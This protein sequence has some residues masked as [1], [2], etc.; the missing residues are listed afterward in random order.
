M[1]IYKFICDKMIDDSFGRICHKLL[2]SELL[3]LELVCKEFMN[4]I[5]KIRLHTKSFKITMNNKN[6][7]ETHQFSNVF[8]HIKDDITLLLPYVKHCRKLNL[9]YT[10]IDD[11]EHL[12]G[13]YREIILPYPIAD[14]IIDHISYGTLK[15]I[16]LVNTSVK[17][18]C[19]NIP[20]IVY[21][22]KFNDNFNIYNYINLGMS[23]RKIFN[24]LLYY[25][26]YELIE[27]ILS[28]NPICDDLI[29]ECNEKY[30]K[31][32]TMRFYMIVSR[33]Q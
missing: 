11:I 19:Q 15:N 3:L 30:S 21:D 7:L 9:A 4:F 12:T 23:P 16:S 2:L 33:I 29:F 28:F 24:L 26:I 20:I 17:Y 13:N 32:Q 5:R 10:N 27:P 14:I 25:K 22:Y 18:R 6:I 31:Y 1:I 8:I